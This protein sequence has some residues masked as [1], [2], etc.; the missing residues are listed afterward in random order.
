M[1]KK[2]SG[3][4]EGSNRGR[5]TSHSYSQRGTAD[6]AP[7]PSGPIAGPSRH[8]ATHSSRFLD[9][10]IMAPP[11]ASMALGAG[12]AS[13]TA[14]ASHSPADSDNPNHSFTPRIAL[15]YLVVDGGFNPLGREFAVREL[16]THLIADVMRSIIA[17]STAL[18]D[19]NAS[20]LVLW[21]PL[22]PLRL[23]VDDRE[24]SALNQLLVVLRSKP[25]SVAQRLRP[26]F[27]V[28]T[29]FNNE[30]LRDEHLHLIV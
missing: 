2:R 22:E 24:T 28:S 14:H 18:G 20:S 19:A 9:P 8:Y 12:H 13:L 16:P 23:D 6:P 27:R 21:K 17:E 1:G 4:G 3:R 29:Y 11:S 7:T 15:I 5:A 30:S 26:S 25:E 10:D